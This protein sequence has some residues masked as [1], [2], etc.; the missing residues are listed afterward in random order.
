VPFLDNK[1]AVET[2]RQRRHCVKY[3]CSNSEH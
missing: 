1:R 2:P 3:D